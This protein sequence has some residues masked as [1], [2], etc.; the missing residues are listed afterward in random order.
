MKR[1][2]FATV[3]AASLLQMPDTSMQADIRADATSQPF[4]TGIADPGVFIKNR[5][6]HLAH[7]QTLLDQLIA[8]KARRTV[9][10]TLR[11][12]DDILIELS[13]AQGGANILE[14]HPDEAFQQSARDTL[15]RVGA[16]QTA[17]SLSPA[18]YRALSEID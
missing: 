5:D 18:V 6:T 8:V 9:E 15:D 14:R 16:F 4:L 2:V 13:L 7:A 11:V 10:N 12:Y 17:L 1:A 3:L